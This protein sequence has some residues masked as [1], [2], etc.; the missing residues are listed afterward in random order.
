MSILATI[1]R[2][3][4]LNGPPA[5]G[6]STLA[7][8]YAHEHPLTLCLDIDVVRS[9]LGDWASQPDE[10]GLLARRLSI[11]MGRS[12]LEAGHDVVVPQFLARADFIVQLAELAA[13]IGAAFVEVAL[14]ATDDDVLAWFSARSADPTTSSHL[15]AAELL[16]RTGGV[17][18]L[19]RMLARWHDFMASR[20]GVATIPARAA[21]VDR[22]LADLEAVLAAELPAHRPR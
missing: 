3:V 18:E 11:A 19:R 1:V 20:P 8:R 2:L 16:A 13:E 9:M 6:K 10:A 21:Y 4:L 7:A 17:P 22:S 12:A 15:D 14:T 5:T